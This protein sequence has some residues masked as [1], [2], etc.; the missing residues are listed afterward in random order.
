MYV[1]DLAKTDLSSVSDKNC[2]Y[3]GNAARFESVNS[4]SNFIKNVSSTN[5][6]K[7][8]FCSSVSWSHI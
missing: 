3:L 7:I 5:S 6:T 2:H 4:I 8:P 1:H